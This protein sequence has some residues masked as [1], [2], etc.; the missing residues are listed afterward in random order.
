MNL[1]IKC[2]PHPKKGGGGHVKTQGHTDSLGTRP[3]E[4]G[5]KETSDAPAGQGT[6]RTTAT[7]GARKEAQ[8]RPSSEAPGGIRLANTLTFSLQGCQRRNF[9]CFKPLC[10]NLLWQF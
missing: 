1:K 3:S 10:G 8:H 4:D 2:A 5:D 7:V 6:P 9:C